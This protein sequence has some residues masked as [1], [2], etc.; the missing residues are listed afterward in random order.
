MPR[1]EE[2]LDTSSNVHF[3]RIELQTVGGKYKQIEVPTGAINARLTIEWDDPPPQKLGFEALIN[4]V[5]NT[6]FHEPNGETVNDLI[7]RI[8]AAVDLN[9]RSLVLEVADELDKQFQGEPTTEYIT[10]WRQ[11]TACM[12]KKLLERGS[13][14]PTTS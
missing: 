1:V 11:A 5:W 13:D 12:E 9:F 14:G 6:W 10:G 7:T 2:Q 4:R 8:S 3:S